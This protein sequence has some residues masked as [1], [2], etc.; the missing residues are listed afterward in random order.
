MGDVVAD[1]EDVGLMKG[2]AL[3]PTVVARGELGRTRGDEGESRVL[4]VPNVW[5]CD[6]CLGV[7]VARELEGVPDARRSMRF[8]LAGAVAVL[9][10]QQTVRWQSRSRVAK[11]AP[12][13]HRCC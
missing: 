11:V 13:H 5:G 10:V 4:K 1:R 3:Y 9:L 6:D 7:S 8:D 2:V 12:P